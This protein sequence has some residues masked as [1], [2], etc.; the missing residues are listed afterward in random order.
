MV[1]VKTASEGRQVAIKY[2]VLP[3]V[4]RPREA[5]RV[6]PPYTC[7]NAYITAKVC[8][9]SQPTPFFMCRS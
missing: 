4:H 7:P 1:R 2:W 3:G 5:A 8:V 6:I 9:P